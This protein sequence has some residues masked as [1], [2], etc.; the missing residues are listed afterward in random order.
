MISIFRDDYKA[1]NSILNY[2]SEQ[3][4]SK[5][6]DFFMDEIPARGYESREGQ[7]DMA[8]DICDAIKSQEHI[9]IEAGVGIGKSYAYLVPLIYYNNLT[10]HPVIISTSSIL[11]QEQLTND[12]KSISEMLHLYPEVVLA[13]GM[14][15]FKCLKRASQYLET[16]GKCDIWLREWIED[17]TVGD[18]K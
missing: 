12:I 6:W 8:L 11:L 10:G 9:I 4:T 3:I 5:V 17:E 16:K 2:Y 15:H 7:E 13:K 1:S 14:T 18:R